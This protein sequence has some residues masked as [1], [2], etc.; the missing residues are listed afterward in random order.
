MRKTPLKSSIETALVN[1]EQASAVLIAVRHAAGE[2]EPC[3]ISDAIDVCS[4]LV[5][6]AR[7]VLAILEGEL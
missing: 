3:D 5:N 7:C 2:M 6:E 4:G 1:I